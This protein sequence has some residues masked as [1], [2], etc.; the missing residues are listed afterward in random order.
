MNESYGTRSLREIVR[1]LFRHWVLLVLI[2]LIGG[3]GTYLVCEY[4]VQK[5][6]RSDISLIFKRPVNRSPVSTDAAGERT[7]EVFVKAQQQIVM[8]D[9]VLARTFVLV[10]DGA[11][12]DRWYKLQKQWY[13]AKDKGETETSDAYQKIREFVDEK[14]FRAA[15][16]NVLTN[17]QKDFLR[18][19]KAVKLETPGG[20]QVGM[21]ETFKLSVDQAG[22]PMKAH[23]AADILADM[24]MVRYQEIQQ[25]LS[26]PAV[27]VINDVIRDFRD[28][29]FAQAI[30]DYQNFVKTNSDMIGVLEQLLKS[31]TEH[32]TQIILTKV[33]END[34]SLFMD[35]TRDK[36][37]YDVL[38]KTL[39]EKVFESGGLDRLSE[40]EIHSALSIIPTE[41]FRENL[42][43]LELSKNMARLEEKKSE[44]EAQYTDGNMDVRYIREEV[45]RNKRRLLDA[46][47]SYARGLEASIEARDQQKRMYEELVTKTREEQNEIHAKLADYA[48]LKNE[49]EVAQKQLETLQVDRMNAMS[50]KLYARETVTINKLD[51]ASIPAADKPVVPLT[52]IYTIVAVAVSMLLGIAFAFLADHF[53]HTLRSSIEAE[54][55]LGVPV[56]G[57]IKRRGRRLIV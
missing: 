37:V 31:G 11:L 35:L 27:R 7:L 53:D 8:S 32:G 55:Y 15:V 41:F 49:F 28:T 9:H 19:R 4:V 57:S 47:V 13:A 10:E 34:A 24:Y 1:I 50:N 16:N 33:R 6:Y 2:V 29:E 12:R 18:F 48:R 3:L 56:L 43:F 25:E 26:D 44:L 23:Y 17:R 20:E 38:R 21:T 5:Q 30:D 36:A 14:A 39:P 42:L 46:V 52:G 45:A 54:R 40:P 22:D 51:P